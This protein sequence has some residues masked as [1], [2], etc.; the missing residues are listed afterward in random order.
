MAVAAGGTNV[1]RENAGKMLINAGTTAAVVSTDIF[2]S[3]DARAVVTGMRTRAALPRDAELYVGYM[4]P[5]VSYDLRSESDLAVVT[6][7]YAMPRPLGR[8]ASASRVQQRKEHLERRCR[9]EPGNGYELARMKVVCGL[10][11]H[12]L[13]S[14]ST[15]AVQ[16]PRRLCIGRW[17]LLDRL[18]L[19]PS[20]HSRIVREFAH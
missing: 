4:H 14:L 9:S 2:K 6:A 19:K 10:K 17:Y 1:I 11:P 8:M 5:D 20:P 12:V 7:S 18:S 16:V 13:P 3:R 15:V